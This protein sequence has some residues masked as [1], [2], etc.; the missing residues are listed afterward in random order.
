MTRIYSIKKVEG[1]K[2]FR[3]SNMRYVMEHLF[4]DFCVE[5]K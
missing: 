5:K 2:F 1:L 4:P 3:V